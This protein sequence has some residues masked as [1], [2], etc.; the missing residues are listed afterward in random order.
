MHVPVSPSP[1]PITEVPSDEEITDS[2]IEFLAPTHNLILDWAVIA[3]LVVV[4]IGGA[5][6]TAPFFFSRQEATSLRVMDSA[7]T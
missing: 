5:F 1:D 4:A 2:N 3:I 7:C 6:W